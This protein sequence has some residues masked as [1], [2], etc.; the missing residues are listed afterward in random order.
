MDK[1]DRIIELQKFAIDCTVALKAAGLDITNSTKHHPLVVA[2]NET[3][4]RLVG[5]VLEDFDAIPD[6]EALN[7][8]FKDIILGVSQG[9]SLSRDCLV[10]WD[11]EGMASILIMREAFN[12]HDL[13]IG[14]LFVPQWEQFTRRYK[15]MLIDARREAER[16]PARAV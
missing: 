11:E 13:W 15:D 9:D 12:T 8:R 7:L 14:G 2:A 1:Y 10:A 16:A 5:S 4:G 6:T 3:Y